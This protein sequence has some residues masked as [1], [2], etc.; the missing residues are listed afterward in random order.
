V[1][2]LE[3][4]GDSISKVHQPFLFHQYKPEDLALLRRAVQNHKPGAVEEGPKVAETDREA[5]WKLLSSTKDVD[6]R[7]ALDILRPQLKE[8]M[9][10]EEAL[11]LFPADFFSKTP[12]DD[13][14]IRYEAYIGGA[15][16]LMYYRIHVSAQ[17]EVLNYGFHR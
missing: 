9:R 15:G 7:K 3:R 2:A 10:A 5:I 12:Q 13:G 4:K 6:R 8:G 17:G 14:K 16:E 11:K 1:Y